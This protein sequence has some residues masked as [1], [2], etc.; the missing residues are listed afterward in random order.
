MLSSK[1]EGN[2]VSSNNENNQY[3]IQDTNSPAKKK[4]ILQVV[5]ALVSGGVERGTIEIAKALTKTGHKSIVISSGGALVDSLLASGSIHE[6]FDVASKNPFKIL[7]NANRIADIVRKYDVDIIHVR[8]RAPAWSCAIAA[9][10]TKRKFITTFHGIYNFSNFIKKYYNSIMTRGHVV[11]AVS[12]FVKEHIINNYDIR[13]QKIQVIHRGVNHKEFCKDQLSSKDIDNFRAKYNLPKFIKTPDNQGSVA[14]NLARIPLLLLPARFTSWKGQIWLAQTLTE[15]RDKDFYCIMAGDLAKHPKYVERLKDLIAKN[16]MQG[17]IQIFG[18]EPD[19]RTLYGIADIVL[20]TSLEP[21]AFGRTIIEAQ[22]ME[23][24]V[25]ATSAGGSSETIKND[26]T[27]FH[28]EPG[29]SSQLK[30][31]IEYC[32][33]ILGSEEEKRIT[34][35]ARED[36][37]KHFSL[38]KMLSSVLKIYDGK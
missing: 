15:M 27:G 26:E 5:P 16:K 37:I 33:S 38:D 20:S 18:N 17:K 25:I 22:S 1:S 11:I 2:V 7:S 12:N 8:S 10:K 4:T 14:S 21:E 19:I 36:V 23:K 35:K 31:K 32:L 24:L 13:P 29:N 28:V 3:D 34:S 9:A 30:E 6:E